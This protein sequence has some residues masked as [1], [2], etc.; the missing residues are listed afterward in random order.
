M[1]RFIKYSLKLK[2]P[3]MPTVLF[4]LAYP[5][6]LAQT[7]GYVKPNPD[8][9]NFERMTV[10][11]MLEAVSGKIPEEWDVKAKAG[12]VADYCT[13]VVSLKEGLE[14][15]T[16]FMDKTQPPVTIEQ[17]RMTSGI[18]KG[19]LEEAVLWTLKT[20]FTLSGLE[21]AQKLTVYEYA[22]ARKNIYNEAVVAYNE[23]MAAAARAR[24]NR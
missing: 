17:Q 15:F 7:C 4:L 14:N 10:K 6:A 3:A 21:A 19:N 8:V 2:D 13:M 12:T 18:I 5:D 22:V 16:K 1:G 24:A 20:A 11:G 9:W 23:N